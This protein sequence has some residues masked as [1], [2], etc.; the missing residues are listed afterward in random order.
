MDIAGV[1]MYATA[2]A[3]EFVA[4]PEYLNALGKALDG[5][6]NNFQLVLSAEGINGVVSERKVE[7]I[8]CW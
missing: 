5:C 4:Q 8:H 1:G 3:G 7:A 6:G 2:A